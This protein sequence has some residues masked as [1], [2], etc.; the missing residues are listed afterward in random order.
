MRRLLM[1]AVLAAIVAVA[2]LPDSAAAT[3]TVTTTIQPPNGPVGGMSRLT[4]G[5]HGNCL[6][7]VSDG[8][9]LDWGSWGGVYTNVYFR[10]R[11]TYPGIGKVGTVKL[12]PV[13]HQGCTAVQATIKRNDGAE[14][15]YVYYLHTTRTDTLISNLY[16]MTS[17]WPNLAYA[18]EMVSSDPGCYMEGQHTHQR[19]VSRPGASS[20]NYNVFQIPDWRTLGGPGTP[21]WRDYVTWDPY[22]F[23]W[24]IQWPV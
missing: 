13:I 14:A 23:P 24:R 12:E 4:C 21:E 11:I 6:L 22:S 17:Y 9:G 8:D 10:A 18:G 1:I 2:I 5:W 3:A 19:A 20:F 16:G 15:A 7:P